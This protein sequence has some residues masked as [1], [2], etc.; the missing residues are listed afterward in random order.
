MPPRRQKNPPLVI[1]GMN[2]GGKTRAGMVRRGSDR[3]PFSERAAYEHMRYLIYSGRAQG[4]AD[5]YYDALKE[6][7]R[8]ID[9]MESQVA[10]G[11]H[12]NPHRANPGRKKRIGTDVQAVIYR[13]VDGTNRV[14]GFGN[15]DIELR[16][17]PDGGVQVSRMHERTGVTMYGDPDGTVTLSGP[18]GEAVWGMESDV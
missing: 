12:A 3:A 5:G 17:L 10:R 14:H 13:H 6:I 4:S 7:E 1:F 16:D 18:D 2:P 8:V 9:T 15:A 11:V